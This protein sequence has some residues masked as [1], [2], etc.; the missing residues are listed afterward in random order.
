MLLAWNDYCANKLIDAAPFPVLMQDVIGDQAHS[1]DDY[2]NGL[3][4]QAMDDYRI[5]EQSE[6][7][8]PDIETDLAG[9]GD[10]VY[11]SII[12]SLKEGYGFISDIA[13]GNVFFHRS[14]VENCDFESLRI[15]QEVEYTLVPSE[16]QPSQYQAG[17]VRVIG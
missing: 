8:A 17:W 14:K 5:R 1:E 2:V 9:S 11:K 13:R 16:N 7:F 15:G 6:D 4:M 10:R 12:F 3:F